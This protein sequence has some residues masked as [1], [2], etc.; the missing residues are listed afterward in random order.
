MSEKKYKRRIKIIK[1]ELQLK[2]ICIF[3]GLSALGI[4][5]QSVLVAHRLSQLSADIPVGGQYIVDALPGLLTEII[6]FTFGLVLPLIFAVGV[7]VTHRIAGPVYRFE[8][9]LGQV[10]RGEDVG[11][12]RIRKGDELQDLCIVINE[13]AELIRDAR[14]HVTSADELADAPAMRRAG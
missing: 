14:S 8:Q 5:L 4:L 9:Y 10:V 1:P 12:C 6:I 3:V 11:P 13:A 2:M 7:L